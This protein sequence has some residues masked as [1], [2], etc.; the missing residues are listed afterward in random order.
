MARI[1]QYPADKKTTCGW[2]IPIPLAG[3]N[4]A[5]PS[6]EVESCN[7]VSVAAANER[8]L[9]ARKSRVQS[10]DRC[11]EHRTLI[12]AS[13]T[14]DGERNLNNAR[15]HVQ[16]WYR[17]NCRAMDTTG[18]NLMRII[19]NS[20]KTTAARQDHSATRR[21]KVPSSHRR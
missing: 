9:E 16:L 19:R 20:R 7:G 11:G 4:R 10:P 13:W 17:T 8:P 5:F 12:R 21:P 18:R 2:R 6:R 3:L 14:E 1:I 15:M